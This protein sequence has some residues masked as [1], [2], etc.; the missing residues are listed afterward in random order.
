[1]NAASS[2]I[3]DNCVTSSLQFA[4]SQL[5]DEYDD[6]HRAIIALVDVIELSGYVDLDLVD[7]SEQM[8]SMKSFLNS[9]IEARTQFLQTSL[10][11]FRS[12]A[13]S[14]KAAYDQYA[15]SF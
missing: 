11:N 8:D 5:S 2:W 7:L 12:Q 1:M 14:L 9:K 15:A 6:L 10:D 13:N 3:Q 4:V